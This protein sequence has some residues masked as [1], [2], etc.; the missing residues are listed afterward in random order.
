VHPTRR[1]SRIR[2]PS[3]QHIKLRR[4]LLLA[5]DLPFDH[6][7]PLEGCPDYTLYRL[8]GAPPLRGLGC[9]S[10][11][12]RDDMTMTREQCEKFAT[13]WAEAWNH[14][15]IDAVLE[16]FVEDV[17]FTSPTAAAVVGSPV[18]RGKQALRA[19]WTT[20]LRRITS[21]HFTVDRVLWDPASRELAIVY[22]SEINGSAKRVSENLTFNEDGR[23]V[24]AEVFHGV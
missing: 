16:H 6:V 1:D 2:Y 23:V 5:A 20:A 9:R 4:I 21:L 12:T 8:R 18:V 22:T 10:V 11:G 15:A 14:R 17:V 13:I 3:S 24:T 7:T 19:Y